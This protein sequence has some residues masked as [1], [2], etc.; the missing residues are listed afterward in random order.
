MDEAI[1]STVLALTSVDS[2]LVT[3]VGAPGELAEF[4]LSLSSEMRC[5][6]HGGDSETWYFSL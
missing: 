2:V 6:P 1:Y 3:T 4:S 5:T